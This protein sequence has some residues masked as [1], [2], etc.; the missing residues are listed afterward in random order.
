MIIDAHIHIE[1]KGDGTLYSPSEVVEAMDAGGVDISLVYGNDQG[2]IGTRPVW[3]H[4]EVPVATEF[5]D[6]AVAEFCAEFPERLVGVSSIHPSRYRPE[7]KIRRA[8]E[9]FGLRG[10]KLYP[11]SG[12]YVNDSR[13]Y[14]VYE[15]CQEA[16]VPVIIH[17]GIK[18]VQWQH[19]K[20][21]CPIYVDDVATDFRN[22][23]IIMCHGGYPWTEEFI[24]LAG[25]ASNTYVD[26]S[27][28]DYIERKFAFQGLTENI[29]RRLISIIGSK[30]LIWG[31]EGPFM[32]LPLYG[33]HGPDNYKQSQDFL[34]NRFD[35][36]NNEDK[37]NIL[38]ENARRLFMKS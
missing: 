31:S 11:H 18:A 20:Y 15:Y 1:T 29:V 30:R 23:N 16:E 35:F 9:E 28:L 32:N 21:N 4:D 13:L 8:V 37:K 19:M 10:V 2:D 7:K 24:A 14:P 12:F 22:L 26:I 34:V 33:S 25:T 36:L 5:S 3:A 38:G 6:E 27:F 17:T